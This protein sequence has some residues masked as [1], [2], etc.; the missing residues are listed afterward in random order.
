MRLIQIAI[1]VLMLS[2]GTVLTTCS[3]R[4]VQKNISTHTAMIFSQE[5][6]LKRMFLV[7]RVQTL[8]SNETYTT[9]I[10][11]N[12]WIV[13]FNPFQVLYEPG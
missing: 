4:G 1:V 3:T 9:V 8:F 12:L 7:G 11:V 2:C 6:L 5:D 13:F 10:A